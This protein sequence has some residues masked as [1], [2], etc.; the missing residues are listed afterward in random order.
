MKQTFDLRP[1]KLHLRR[2]FEAR[3]WKAEESFADYYHEKTILANRV[4][5]V[6]DELLDYL[7]EGITDLRLQ[8]TNYE[9]PIEDGT[10]ESF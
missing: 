1:R 10:P 8:K 2:E 7:V 3:V 5:I 6:E 9:F 4:P